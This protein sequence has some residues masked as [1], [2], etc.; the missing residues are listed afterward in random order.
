MKRTP[1]IGLLLGGLIITSGLTADIPD[2]SGHYGISE[3]NGWSTCKMC[4][5]SDF[6]GHIND[7]MA[8]AHWNWE[9][10]DQ[11]NTSNVGKI[12]AINN[13]CV[14]VESNE[15]RCTSCHIGIG[16]SDSSFDLTN[17]DNIDCFVCHDGTGAYVKNPKGAGAPLPLPEGTTYAD[18]IR[19]FQLPD[20]DN[21][22]A[23][24]FYGGG[25]EGVK[26]GTM[27]SSLSMPSREVDVH[28]GGAAN[29][30]CIDCH[31]MDGKVSNSVDMY[32]TRYSHTDGLTDVALC[33]DCHDDAA[34]VHSGTIA[35]HFDKIAC[36]TCHIPAMARGGKPT[37]LFWD[38]STAGDYIANPD[39]TYSADK[40]I[41][42]DNGW[43]IYHSKKGDFVWGT[44]VVPEYKWSNGKVTSLTTD[45]MPLA[46]DGPTQ[47]NTLEGGLNDGLIF[48]VKVF[49][50]VQPADM[51]A[52]TLAVPNLFPGGTNGAD[53]KTP[54]I[55]NAYWAGYDWEKAVISGQQAAGNAWVGPLGWVESEYTWIQSHMVAPKE[56]ALDCIDCHNSFGRLDFAALGLNASNQTWMDD[57]VWAGYILEDGPYFDTGAWLGEVYVSEI[58]KPWVYV[59]DLAQWLYIP[60]EAI[61]N[62]GSWTFVPAM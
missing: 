58:T 10:D 55:K 38:W 51:G 31:R 6:T 7:I 8:S 52:G 47:I 1:I 25:A 18:V 50:G 46:A 22:G 45:N 33:Q 30:T 24:H 5:S 37:K 28:M 32:G 57:Q 39:G 36:Q 41:K 60:H 11:N 54:G 53:D 42:D 34:S 61:L 15:P 4:H 44:D 59:F 16:W 9:V 17:P 21:C 2:M 29:L 3:Y 19:S 56:M 14:A 23:C 49:K 20:R 48:P 40:V 62:D 26:H 27:D 13:F 43:V 35:G 12:N